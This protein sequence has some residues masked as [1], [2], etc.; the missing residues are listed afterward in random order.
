MSIR[1]PEDVQQVAGKCVEGVWKVTRGYLN[2]TG[3]FLGGCMKGV[4]KMS[5]RCL[6]VSEG[7]LEYGFWKVSRKCLEGI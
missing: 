2:I 1:C 4:L 6:E 3:K 7:C 5:G